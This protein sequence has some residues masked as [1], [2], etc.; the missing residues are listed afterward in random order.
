RTGRKAREAPRT[1]ARGRATRASRHPSAMWAVPVPLRASAVHSFGIGLS[2]HHYG[3]RGRSRKST[4]RRAESY[5][6]RVYWTRH[7]WP[8][9][10]SVPA[11]CTS[12]MVTALG[13]V[14]NCSEDELARTKLVV[15]DS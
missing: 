2:Q 5:G 4:D 13:R 11:V 10:P 3:S 15:K 8:D 7:C 1:A 14:Q 6:L 12:R 9:A